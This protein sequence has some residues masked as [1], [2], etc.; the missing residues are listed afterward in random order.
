MRI[1]TRHLTKFEDYNIIMAIK[2]R[3]QDVFALGHSLDVCN[4]WSRV[5]QLPYQ[6]RWDDFCDEK[7]I[8]PRQF[9]F[10]LLCIV[11][12]TDRMLRQKKKL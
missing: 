7:N 2:Q 10:A 5:V 4:T 8:L 11:D 12:F 6:L 9:R 1:K 3:R